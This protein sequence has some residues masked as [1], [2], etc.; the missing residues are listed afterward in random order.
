MGQRTQRPKVRGGK[1]Y[2]DSSPQTE[3]LPS[4]SVTQPSLFLPFSSLSVSYLAKETTNKKKKKNNK[5]SNEINILNW[6]Q[7]KEQLRSRV[8]QNYLQH[9]EAKLSFLFSN[10]TNNYWTTT[11]YVR[12]YVLLFWFFLDSTYKEIRWD[13][14]F[15]DSEI[16]YLKLD[17]LPLIVFYS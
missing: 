11:I 3:S 12:Y 1:I 2:G 16:I 4:S 17:I 10:P 8:F 9:S 15:S 6:G 7:N 5:N 14:S 13:L